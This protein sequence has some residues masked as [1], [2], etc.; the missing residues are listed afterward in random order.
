MVALFRLHKTSTPRR[1]PRKTHGQA[2]IG[3]RIN[4]HAAYPPTL[5]QRLPSVYIE[6]PSI[7]LFLKALHPVLGKALRCL[8]TAEGYAVEVRP[9]VELYDGC[10]SVCLYNICVFV[11]LHVCLCS[12]MGTSVRVCLVCIHLSVCLGVP[13]YI[14]LCLPVLLSVYQ[15]AYLSR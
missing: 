10:Q 2:H 5:L 12:C 8:R 3:R 1:V 14:G 6:S 11:C 13:Q 9:E 4:T 15:Y 7:T